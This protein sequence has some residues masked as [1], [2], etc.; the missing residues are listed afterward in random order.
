M[1]E[2][3][4]G[5]RRLIPPFPNSLSRVEK[6]ALT[7]QRTPKSCAFLKR[8]GLFEIRVA[9]SLGE[10]LVFKTMGGIPHGPDRSQRTKTETTN[11]C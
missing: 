11:Y 9:E 6:K 3:W 8:R 1:Q 4:L 10:L 5:G 7:S 2:S